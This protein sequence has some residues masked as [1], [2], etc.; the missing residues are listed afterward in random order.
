MGAHWESTGK[1]FEVASNVGNPK[2][3]PVSWVSPDKYQDYKINVSPKL[4]GEVVDTLVANGIEAQLNPNV[5]WSEL[6]AGDRNIL[7][8]R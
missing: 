3:Q 6:S 2:K 8:R 4:A 5:E 1:K 7:L